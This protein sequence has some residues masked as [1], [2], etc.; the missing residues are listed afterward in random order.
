MKFAK[1]R[2]K[3]NVS[4]IYYLEFRELYRLLICYNDDFVFVTKV[5]ILPCKADDCGLVILA[6]GNFSG[7]LYEKVSET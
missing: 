5:F 2:N 7:A 6:I 1:Y 3:P 4:Y